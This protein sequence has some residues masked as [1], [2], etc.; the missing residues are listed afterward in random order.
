MQQI[1]HPLSGVRFMPS[2]IKHTPL[3]SVDCGACAPKTHTNAGFAMW[4]HQVLVDHKNTNPLILK[5]VL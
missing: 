3:Q 4:S 1:S 5:E 2:Q